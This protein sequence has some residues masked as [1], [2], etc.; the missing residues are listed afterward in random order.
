MSLKSAASSIEDIQ[1]Q[2]AEVVRLIRSL[3]F[4]DDAK[5]AAIKILRDHAETSFETAKR[6]YEKGK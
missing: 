3:P 1:K 4:G 6:I 5:D 2:L